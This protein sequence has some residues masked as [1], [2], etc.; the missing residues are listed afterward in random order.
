MHT[1][2]LCRYYIN[3]PIN[4]NDGKEA[5]KPLY[6]YTRFLFLLLAKYYNIK[7]SVDITVIHSLPTSIHDSFL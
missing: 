4:N 1:Y 2:A 7:L 6:T 3:F 5:K